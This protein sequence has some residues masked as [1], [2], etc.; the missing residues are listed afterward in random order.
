M[1]TAQGVDASVDSSQAFDGSRSLRIQYKDDAQAGAGIYQLIALELNRS[2][3]LSGWYKCDGL[4]AINPPRFYIHA[5]DTMNMIAATSA[6]EGSGDWH[7]FSVSFNSGNTRLG[8][9]Q[10][11]RV[12]PDGPIHGTLWIDSIK[13][14][15]E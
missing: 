5:V 2:Y 3:T 7:S 6:F 9:L 12:P 8:R 15:P 13:L 1:E 4:T 14:A 10:L 11:M